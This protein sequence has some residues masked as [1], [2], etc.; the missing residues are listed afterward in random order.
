MHY[1]QYY[2]SCLLSTSKRKKNVPTYPLLL[3]P[4]V[5]DRLAIFFS[6]FTIMLFQNTLIQR[7]SS[8]LIARTM[9]TQ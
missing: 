6:V 5:E 8:P 1:W 9:S 7:L 4:T 2:H 3:S